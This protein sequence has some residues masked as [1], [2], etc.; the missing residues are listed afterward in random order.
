[1]GRGSQQQLQLSQ[2][3]MRDRHL[4]PHLVVE[5]HSLEISQG[6]LSETSSILRMLI[7]MRAIS[8]GRLDILLGLVNRGLPKQLL[9]MRG[10]QGLVEKLAMSVVVP[11]I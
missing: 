1:M 10:V 9:L 2:Q 4:W 5:G 8:V 7:A 11:S 6:V 3:V